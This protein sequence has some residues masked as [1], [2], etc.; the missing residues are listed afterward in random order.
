V[1]PVMKIS[2]LAEKMINSSINQLKISAIFLGL[3]IIRVKKAKIRMM[4]WELSLA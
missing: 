1:A 4:L 3:I 2:L